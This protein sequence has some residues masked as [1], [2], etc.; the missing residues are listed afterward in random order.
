MKY[1]DIFVYGTLRRGGMYADYL[2]RSELIK[3]AVMLAGYA[4]YD[5]QQWY[6]YLVRQSDSSVVGDIYRVDDN[7]LS[8]LHELEGV[9]DQ[10]FRFVFLDDQNCYTYLKYDQDLTGLKYIKGGDWLSYYQSLPLNSRYK[11]E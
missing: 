11:E 4:I 5:Y 8:E 3:E 2:S 9:E 6:P 10:L 1:Y 7:T